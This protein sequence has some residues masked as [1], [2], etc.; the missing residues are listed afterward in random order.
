MIKGAAIAA[1]ISA[2]LWVAGC[3]G[4]SANVVTVTVSPAAAT[5]VAGQQYSFTA[6]VGGSTTTTVVWTCTYSYT[7]A[8]TQAN[9][10]PKAVTGT[11]P[12][13]GSYGTL[14]S[15]TQTVI[16]FTAPALSKF[17]DP[18][19]TITLTATADAD[20]GKTGTA[21]I[22][23]DSGIRVSITP[24]A[25]T[26]PVGVTPAQ[27]VQFT[28]SLL[29]ST[30][31]NLKWLVTQPNTSSSTTV[32]QTAN[33]QGADCSATC[34]SV[35]ANGVFTAPATLPTDTTPSGSASTSPTT[36]YLVVWS[37]ADPTQFAVATLTLISAT[38][39]PVTFTGIS[40][41]MVA[42][43]GVEQDIFLNAKNL[44]NT[45]TV[46]FTPPNGSPQ[47]IAP[48]NIFTVPI[49]LAYCTPSA[50]GVTPVVTCD[51][52]I[53]TRVRLNQQ[54]LA[55]PGTATITVNNIPDPNNPGNTTSISFPLTLTYARPGLVS[56]APD[57][58]P[59][60][61]N[62]SFGTDGG[63]YG[64]GSS[65]IVK[66]LFNGVLN[67]ATS[68]GPRQFTGPL[69]ASQIPNPGL[70]PISIVSNA[71]ASQATP[72]PFPTVTTDVAVQ[73]TFSSLPLAVPNVPLPA[74]GSATN[75]VPSAIAINSNKSYAVI[76]EQA[77]NTIQI[78]NLT[79][80]GPVPSGAPIAVGSQPT[81]VAIDDQIALSG[82]P[83][84]DLGVVVNSGDGTL[85]LIALP[86][87][88][89]VAAP[90]SMNGLFT[91]ALNTTT[92]STPFSVGVDPSS[93]LAVVAFTN[94][95]IGFIV[96]V[97][98]GSTR[99]TCF[100]GSAAKHAPCPIASVSLN[101]G[102]TP[103]VVMQPN[104]PLAYVTPG[105]GGV[106]SVV[107]LL[108]T[109][110]SVA[111]AGSSANPAGAI[112]TNSIVT[113]ITTTPHGIN[114]AVGG[115]VLIS[116]VSPADLNGTYQVI[117]GSVTDPYTFQYTQTGNNLANESGGGGTVTYGSP[118]YTFNVTN[119][120]TGAAIN[121]VT[122]TIALADPN[123][124][125]AQLSFIQTLDQSVTSLTL[126]TGSCNGCTPT[127]AGAPESDFRSVSWDPFT[128]VLVTY[129]P[130]ANAD[131]NLDGNKISL[132]NPGGKGAGGTVTSPYRIIA[133]IPT[134]Q[135]GSGSYTPSGAT[136]PVVV[137]GPM[138]YDP[139]TKYVIVANAGSN[140]LSYLNLDPGNT[141]KPVN[142]R[143]ILVSSGGV[144]SAQPALGSPIPGGC[145][146]AGYTGPYM[147]DGIMIGCSPTVRVFGEGFSASGA[148]VRLD[149]AT[150]GITS[151]VV[152]DGEID[153]TIP[154]SFFAL[155]HD[156]A[157]DVVA[158]GVNS[159]T[160]DLHA[161]LVDNLKSICDPVAKI[162][163]VSTLAGQGPEAVA[164]DEI[165]N[166][167]VVTNYSCNSISIINMDVLN[168]HG[169]GHPYGSILSTISVGAQPIG[170][171]IIPRLGYAV[172]ANNGGDGTTG[173]SSII[174]I[175]NPLK[176]TQ[177]GSDVEVGLSPTGVSFDLDR[178]L[179][180]VAN[181]GSN[182]LSYIDLTVL[183]PGAVTTTTPAA[184]SIATSG[185]PNGIA[186]DPNR[187]E[188][189]VTNLQNSGTSTA[190]GG[191]DVISLSTVPPSKST[192][193]SINTLTA[194]PTGI[195]VDPA[196][197]PI[198]FYA[199]S[200]QQNAV[201][202]FDPDT[203]N[204]QLIRVGINPYSIAYNYQTGTMLTVNSTSNTMSV[205]DT[206]T[207]S[208]QA[209]LGI[210][211]QSQHRGCGRSEQQSRD[212]DCH[213][214]VAALGGRGVGKPL[215]ITKRVM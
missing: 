201:Y 148:Q 5:V 169:Y 37:A 88:T 68:F 76:T 24:S 144:P 2:L 105:G 152:S 27:T 78:V 142:I 210:S 130:S 183:L 193:S 11:C 202:T 167:A 170:V 127:P 191:L 120:V 155:P 96:D 158:G 213:A 81:G 46:S 171:G 8:P 145:N 160:V 75:L 157:L 184:A 20:H 16:T 97:N 126:T 90:I 112:R 13:D 214:Q 212:V 10:N 36:V 172:T 50:S 194:N 209:T 165:R 122:R 4:S 94:T 123:A 32:N 25:A 33:P 125:V 162:G 79:A 54:Q 23:L 204:T 22:T 31:T 200:T 129:A 98:P 161:I 132:I 192:T 84:Q 29:N 206:Q 87:G 12:T 109:N 143:G 21:I 103:Q 178:A 1:G 147:A 51:A 59:Q 15:T 26:V 72:P 28:A 63:Y 146:P 117:P 47:A 95:N 14:T 187:S 180:L 185:P 89:K 60:G 181:A 83:G 118:Y 52:S 34:G 124:T 175:S 135:V 166:I 17:P 139:K 203:S 199:T 205:V 58:V 163:S 30:P 110:T 35:D 211:S 114:P 43:G 42:A 196:V 69:Q 215:A 154:A 45:T 153:A 174:D 198:L 62:T 80:A 53:V 136:A 168:L 173:T 99:S 137:G 101:T 19:P 85:S 44:L 39:N 186:V 91:Q 197:S 18:I 107:N 113:I 6:T 38:T 159:N 82:F 56:A 106:L 111:I 71:Q 128:N 73:P 100:P 40:P 66:L 149:G 182:T 64:G 177:V 93:H 156:Y 67:T 55:T 3:G 150:T 151:T 49:S 102:P 115:T 65:P 140:T 190:T 121:P 48:A 41:T 176:P 195:V 208:T 131:P 164:F 207:F 86:S 7:P 70:Y 141:F 188:A 74:A 119:T 189:V 134:N 138:V 77:T 104:V 57:S 116:G 133:A 9:P 92:T 108:Q 179:A 61:T